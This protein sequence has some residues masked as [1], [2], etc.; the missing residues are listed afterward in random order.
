[1]AGKP[2]SWKWKLLIA[3]IVLVL[4]GIAFVFTPWG[5]S[6]MQGWIDKAYNEMPAAERKD[7]ELA[8][9]QLQLAFWTGFVC[10]SSSHSQ[11]MYLDFLGIDNP[12]F[13]RRYHENY[14]YDWKGKF[15]GKEKT[16]WGI[17]HPRAPE[18]F[19]NYLEL[20]SE[21]Q[22][23]QFIKDEAMKY[24]TLFYEIYPKLTKQYGKPHPNFYVYWDKIKNYYIM[25][26]RGVPPQVAPRPKD[27][28]GPIEQQEGKE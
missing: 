1:M 11:Q 18:A 16:G 27:Y 26:H 25:K 3:F 9:S 20:Y 23:G 10:Q 4:V 7:S 12:D 19:L 2:L 6:A 5:H 22:S 24:Y 8:D 13:F 17:L 21:K 28:P 15:D 14:K